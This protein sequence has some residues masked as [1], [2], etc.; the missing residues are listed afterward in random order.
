ML[1]Q[2]WQPKSNTIIKNICI[3]YKHHSNHFITNCNLHYQF[4]MYIA[5]PSSTS[6]QSSFFWWII[7][8]LNSLLHNMIDLNDYNSFLHLIFLI[9]CWNCE[10]ICTQLIDMHTQ[11]FLTKRSCYATSNSTSYILW[12]QGV[13]QQIHCHNKYMRVYDWH[14]KRLQS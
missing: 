2:L 10:H 4:P 1:K 11:H 5:T 13:C 12:C 3:D 8:E 9:S 7:Q 14:L 6:Y